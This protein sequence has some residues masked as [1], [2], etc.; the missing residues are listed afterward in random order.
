VGDL[1]ERLRGLALQGADAVRSTVER[2]EAALVI[3]QVAGKAVLDEDGK[4]IVEAGL[5]ITPQMA[6]RARRCGRLHALVGAVAAAGA[7]DLRERLDDARRATAEGREQTALDSV[8]DYAAARE[9][10]GHVAVAD[11]TDVRGAVVIRAGTRLDESHIRAAREARL[12]RALIASASMP[13]PTSADASPD[14]STTRNAEVE[15]P[16]DPTKRARL[17]VVDMPPTERDKA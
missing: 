2:E 8:E 14:V 1:L 9:Y 7:Q 11:V 13:Q 6:E 17:P 3:G 10:V 15:P 4:P 12:L 16:R 5:R